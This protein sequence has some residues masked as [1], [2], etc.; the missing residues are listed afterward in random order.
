[1]KILPSYFI[2]LYRGKIINIHPSLLPKYKG[3][4]TH[5]RVI[6][7]KEKFTGCTIH[8]VNRFLDSG[9]IIFQGKVK[10]QKKD[11]YKS[12]ERKVLK[13]EHNIYPKTIDKILSTL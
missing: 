9:K 8:Y 4:N 5:K 3:L 13:I 11:T 10:I 2:K 6:I 1:M 12:I 7:N